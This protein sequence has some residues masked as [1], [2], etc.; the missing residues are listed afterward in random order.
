MVDG[1]HTGKNTFNITFP[2]IPNFFTD[3]PTGLLDLFSWTELPYDGGTLI[4]QQ[5]ADGNVVTESW[6]GKTYPGQGAL[7]FK[8]LIKVN[9]F[10]LQA[11]YSFNDPAGIN[12]FL[13]G[14]G[15]SVSSIYNRSLNLKGDL[16]AVFVAR[17]KLLEFITTQ[18]IL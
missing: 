15:S 14:S 2:L 10:T 11:S 9:S 1:L 4:N 6:E 16:T 17:S 7:S 3:A 13:F 5:M 18:I 12:D 8:P